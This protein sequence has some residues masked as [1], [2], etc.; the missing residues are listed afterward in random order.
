MILYD[1]VNCPTKS[2][3]YYYI[4]KHIKLTNHTIDNICQLCLK[5][6]NKEHYSKCIG[7]TKILLLY[8]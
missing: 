4:K 5:K 6:Y 2:T 3:N 7:I 8:L 1:C